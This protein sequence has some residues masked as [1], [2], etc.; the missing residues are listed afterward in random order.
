MAYKILRSALKHGFTEDDILSVLGMPSQEIVMRH[1][2]LKVLH[3]GF[4]DAGVPLEV[5]TDA[6][7]HDES[8]RVVIHAMRLGKQYHPG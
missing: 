2:P 8:V 3:I 5:I 4:T 7:G 6:S 1:D